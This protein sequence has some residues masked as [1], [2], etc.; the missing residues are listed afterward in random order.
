MRLLLPRLKAQAAALTPEH[1][2]L[3]VDSQQKLD[4]TQ[5]V[6]REAEVTHIFRSGGAL[7]G[8]AVRSGIAA[9]KGRLIIFMDADGSHNPEYLPRL[10][11]ERENA[12]LV[13][14]SRYTTG[15]ATE[16]PAILI[17]L[18]WVVNVTFRIVLGLDCRDVSN[19]LRLYKSEQL[20]QLKLES[21]NFDIVEE[22]LIK[23]CFGAERRK[24]LEV[25]VTFEKRKAG[26]SKR[27]LVVFAFGYLGTLWRLS[28][29][30]RQARRELKA[31]GKQRA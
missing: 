4:D 24:A 18:S 14:G 8:D 29:F 26:H 31:K 30:K 11:A 27:N 25:P 19:S 5:E 21:K 2:I 23:I 22:M 28:K 13:I 1:E 10:W 3:I 9:A 15:G 7:Y 17:F 6:C 12:D 16:N 20:R